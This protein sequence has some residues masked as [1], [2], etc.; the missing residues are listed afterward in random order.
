MEI[1]QWKVVKVVPETRETISY[2]LEPVSGK[3]VQYEAGQF[4]TILIDHHGH[5]LR[6]SYS[7]SSTPGVD[8][9]LSITVKRKVNGAISRYIQV[10]WREGT[11]F[12]T[13]PPTGMFRIDTDKNLQRTFFFIAAGSGIVP[14]FSLLKKVLH[15]EPKSRVVLLYQNFDEDRIIFNQ[16]LQQL[17]T[18]FGERFKRI[19]LLSSPKDHAVYPQRLNNSLLEKLLLNEN[20]M[21]DKSNTFYYTCGPLLFMKMVEFTI[22]VMGFEGAQVRKENFTI[23]SI[24]VPRFSMEP[25]P[26][27]VTVHYGKDRYQFT[28]TYPSSILQSALD[29]HISL[30]Y[31]C[32]AGRCSSCVA[33]CVTGSVKMSVNDIL[34]EKDLLQGL[35]LT[36]VGYAETD[37]VLQF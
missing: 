21:G 20:V 28:T 11:V 14:V 29:N 37:V 22:R 8:E 10:M 33:R 12:N 17:Q 35:V 19:D 3:T 9:Q 36:C 13:I 32:R 24:P 31:S 7:M 5:E 34:T 27:A 2:V 1:L 4:L 16:A 15:F 30:P 23:E 25:L 26:R 18:R 6:R